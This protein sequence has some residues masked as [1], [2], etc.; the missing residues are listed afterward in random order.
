VDCLPAEMI[1]ITEILASAIIE[2][3]ELIEN[4]NPKPVRPGFESGILVLFFEF[5]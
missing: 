2:K 3:R 1:S 4:L 5:L